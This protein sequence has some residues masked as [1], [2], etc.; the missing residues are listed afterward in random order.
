MLSMAITF[1]VT[2][3]STLLIS[4]LANKKVSLQLLIFCKMKLSSIPTL[5]PSDI[6]LLLNGVKSAIT[7][8]LLLITQQLTMMLT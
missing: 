4:V 3:S 6:R 5:S 7:C 8:N 1:I 2:Q